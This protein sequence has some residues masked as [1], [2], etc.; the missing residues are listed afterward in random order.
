MNTLTIEQLLRI[1]TKWV[2]GIFF[3]LLISCSSS[4]KKSNE[5]PLNNNEMNATVVLS[6]GD[7]I[8]INAKESKARMGQSWYGGTF[9]EGTNETNAAI[10]I[11][12]LT[13]I[14]PGTY[15]FSCEYRTNAESSTTPIY[16]NYGVNNRGSITFT[17]LDDHAMEGHFSAVCKYATDSVTVSGS[18]K[19][20]F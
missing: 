5:A 13:V 18:F 12:L 6:S 17:V 15:A 7:I 8:K 10:Y 11:N 2:N 14:S 19:G 4:C 20:N 1:K 9:V 16:V 3:I